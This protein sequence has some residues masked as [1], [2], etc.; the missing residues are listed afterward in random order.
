MLSA[1]LFDLD[2]TLLDSNDA[3]VRAWQAALDERS[4]HVAA[5]RI[6]VEIGKGG[7]QLVSDL[8]GRTAEDA[9][10]DA[11]RAAHDRIF[12][13]LAEAGGLRPMPGATDLVSALRGR[14]LALALATSTRSKMLEVCERASGVAWR[15]LFDHVVDADDVKRSKP[16]PD[17]VAAAV[18][19]LGVTP[20]ECVMF[21]DTPWDATSA[22]HAGVVLVGVLCGGNS[23]RALM[24]A[25]A[26]AVYA[27][28]AI[29]VERAA[30]MLDRASPGTVR[31][32]ARALDALMQHALDAA[33]TALAAGE[34]PIGSVVA[35][36]DGEVVARGWNRL[37]HTGDRTA[38]AEI[39]AFQRAARVL[40][41]RARDT[42]LVSTLEPC[43]M[44]LGAAMEAGV[45]TIVYA[46]RAPDDSGTGRVEP[47]R[48]ADNQMPRIVG[49]IRAHDSRALFEHWLARPDRDRAQEPV[50]RALLANRGDG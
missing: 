30:E 44:C 47:P 1:A 10:G 16:A 39:D 41:P 43:V 6:A 9:D 12:V 49:D 5:D 7:D 2:G 42:I 24:R 48:S 3:H 11:L 19:R 26:R 46:L 32:D 35:R 22:K 20:A 23:E 15:E 33:A 17:I 40:D 34:A 4:Y 37:V 25:G 50:I 28:P 13:E 36:G 8:L 29:I 27:D 18:R 38:H 14:G 21:G 31:L 45:D